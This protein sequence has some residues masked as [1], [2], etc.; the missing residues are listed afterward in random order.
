MIG[1]GVAQE[2]IETKDGLTVW[3]DHFYPE[4]IDPETGAVLPDGEKGELVF[5]SLTKE[6][7]P[8]I[9]YR[10]R[11]LT[12]LLPPTARAMRRIEKITGRSD[13]ML[14]IRGVNVFPTQIEELIL[15]EPALAPH[16]QLE[17][18]RPGNLDELTVLV[19]R[20]PRRASPT[21]TR[22]A[23]GSRTMIK[24][25]IGVT[26]EVRVSRPA[27]SSARS[28][29]PSGSSTSGRNESDGRSTGD[30]SEAEWK[31]RVELAACYRI[32][33]M[34]GWTELIY[35]HIT[36]R[37][38]DSVTGGDKQF[39]INPFGLHY[40]EVHGQQPGE[41]RPAG[42]Q[43]RSAI[44]WP[45]N[46]GRL[47]R[48]CGDPRRHARR[49]LRDA[50]AHD[51]R[52]GGGLHRR[53]GC[54][55]TTSI[56]RS[57]T[58]W[59]RTT[60]SKA[61]P[62]MPTKA[63]RL[64]KQHRR[65][66]G[67]DPAQPRAA[68]LGPTLPLAFARLWTLQRACEIQV[69]Q[70]AMGPAIAVPEAIARKTHARFVPVRPALRR[71][72]GRVRRADAAVDRIDTSLQADMKVCIYGAGAI[73]GWIG[74]Q[75]AQ[76][77]CDVERGG[78]RRDAGGAASA[79]AARCRSGG[80]TLS[81]CRCAPAPRPG[82]P[83][84]AGPGRR[85]GEGA[86]DGRA[87]RSASRRC[88][89]PDTIVLT[90]MNGVPWWFFDGFGGKLCR[91]APEVGRSR[92][93]AS[94]RRFPAG[95]SSAAWCTPAARC[96]EPG[97]VRHHFGNKLIIGEP[98]GDEDAARARRWRRCWTQAGFDADGVDADPDGHLVQAVGQHDDEPDQR[99]HRRDHRPDPRR[100]LV[101]GFCLAV[102]LEARE[103]GA[104]DRHPD[105]A[106]AA[107]TGTQVTRKLGAF[108]T[109]MLQDVEAGKPVELDALVTV[110]QEMGELTRRR[111]RPNIDALL[112]LARLHART[113]GL[114][115]IRAAGGS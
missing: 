2:C 22:R 69:A 21:A 74:A 4:I 64:L 12:R 13:D 78:A 49:A 46:P 91:H 17:I 8:I 37:L 68:G 19:E 67:G 60:T 106:A 66:A 65:Q 48:A 114:Y 51:R 63:P 31:A 32:F 73:G 25:L 29:R 80:E 93:R 42:Q 79:R 111:R 112:G 113:R 59:S 101:R 16:Y 62:S 103:I 115:P 34:L 26:A 102:M 98:S 94:P 10:T 44:R 99:D 96:T 40:S 75:L 36:V 84:R 86:G 14:I 90:A 43:A 24:S 30:R 3:E 87:S 89:G 39:L 7:L 6:A 50:H 1:P 57:C 9:R 107:R 105:R 23:R 108:K 83:R 28:A 95:T 33:A 18:T 81:A 56:R 70:A 55:R 76:A 72:P 52:A 53:A 54:R 92:R 77:G 38:P 11:D 109:S 82:R 104:R 61:S 35:N 15:K 20:A 85:R 110:V 71:R 27:A 45:V 5:T 97:I 47:H 41:D 100:R 88:S 58:T